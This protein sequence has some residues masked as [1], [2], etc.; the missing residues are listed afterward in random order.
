MT[1]VESGPSIGR[2]FKLIAW[3]PICAFL[4]IPGCGERNVYAPPPPPNV[5]VSQPEL[6]TV[7]DYMEFTGNTQA[8]NT[9]ELRARVQGYLE[10]VYFKDGDVV[11]KGQRLFLIQQDTYQAQLKQAEAQILQQ[12]ANLEH[13]TLETAR[14][15]KL[16]QKEAASQTDLDNWRFQRDAFQA[17]VMAAEANRDLAKL[18]L[19]YTTV[20][21]P[22]DGRIGRR[23]VDPGNLVGAGEFTS[24]AQV[25]QIDPLYVY[26]TI[27]E[28][29][30]PGFMGET[31]I[32]AASAEK[33]KIPLS[34]GL[35]NEAG[36]PH[37]GHLDFAAISLS[38]TT[39]TLELRGIF[40][41]PDGKILP[42]LFARVRANIA[43]SEKPSLVIPEVAIG[44]DQL[45]AYVLVVRS[46]NLVERRSV[47]PGARLDSLRV[48][49][50]GLTGED[51]VVVN[52][53]MQAV[54]GRPATPVRKPPAPE[55]E[56]T[57]AMPRA[58]H[59]RKDVS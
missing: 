27:N 41:N 2:K 31:R 46:D 19:D 28:R 7:A 13:A 12:K 59:A 21:S 50:E 34:L 38:S 44:Y 23:L 53:Q 47:K 32:T 11:K 36:Y 45:G 58:N 10:K 1:T 33:K 8:I 43:G 4:V 30:L 37:E 6:R 18:N 48:V 40:P 49:R 52:G 42:G 17:A 16:V 51:W 39:G 3:L 22:F 57:G 15:T 26:F 54:P 56:K 20:T 14:Y 29:D 25:N 9:V 35:A 5:T 55:P 24:L